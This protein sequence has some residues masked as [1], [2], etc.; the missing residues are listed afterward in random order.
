MCAHFGAEHPDQQELVQIRREGQ[1]SEDFVD[2]CHH[3]RHWS[4]HLKVTPIS[5]CDG[6]EPAQ[7]A[8]EAA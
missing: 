4:L 3:P 2:E 1:T 6:F 8:A 5:S 7:D